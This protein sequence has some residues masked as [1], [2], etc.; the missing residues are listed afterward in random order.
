ME[1]INPKIFI[2]T[3]RLPSSILI[4]FTKDLE[5]IF[6]NSYKLC[7]GRK[8]LSNL[9]EICISKGGT[10][11]IL[12]HEHRG[13]PDA[14]VI[15]HLPKGPSAYFTIKKVVFCPKKWKKR[16]NNLPPHIL[17][18]NLNSQIGKRLCGIFSSLFSFP[19]FKSKR[20]ISFIG[21]NNQILFR[22]F[23]YQKKRIKKKASL[24][25]ELGPSFDM[26]P[27]KISLGNFGEKNQ[28]IEWN[29]TSFIKSNGKR[30]F[31]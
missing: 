10:D 22:H 31:L 21:K 24:L 11:I 9:I 13:V 18:D 7:R 19:S 5:N 26:F 20:I 27:F 29:F 1:V 2:T 12:I 4:K 16:N 30:S 17:I 25:H 14:L 28:K 8:F 3:S 23:L 6:S 15:S